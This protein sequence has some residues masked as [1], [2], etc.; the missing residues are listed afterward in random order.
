[1]KMTNKKIAIVINSLKVG[2][3]AEKTVAA[4]SNGLKK[5]GCDVTIFVFSRSEDEY[6]T[7]CQIEVLGSALPKNSLGALL[8][9][10][11]RGREIA[12]LSKKHGIE[13]VV[14]FMEEANFASLAGKIFFGNKAKVACSVRNNPEKKKLFAKLLM[15][16]L[17][18][19][20]DCLAVNSS[21]LAKLVSGLSS[22]VAVLYNPVDY[23]E[24]VRK[25]EEP[26]SAEDERLFADG[27]VF[28]NIG[29][30]HPQKGQ[31]I[32]IKSFSAIA[33]ENPAAELVIIGE[34]QSREF[35]IGLA[36]SLGV[37][38]RVHFL[39]RRNNV[40]PFLRRSKAFVLSSNWEGMPNVLLEAM[41]VGTPI[42]ATDCPTGVRE[43]VAPSS[44]S[45]D[46][47]VT[48]ERGIL[49]EVGNEKMLS[50]AMG[51]A[52][53]EDRKVFIDE[54]FLIDNVLNEWEKII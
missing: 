33:K 38:D 10:F 30:L 23:E 12:S 27:P 22:K 13:T 32:L 37:A 19:F 26:M 16:A 1:M 42:V 14:S 36:S 15:K 25:A 8:A 21:D 4:I 35:L 2:G 18:R 39:G 34:G 31:D 6:E 47:P 40:F 24:A 20:A 7:S 53:T 41:A 43:L 52:I 50:E 11:S 51:K 45:K 49:V 44:D 48:T 28:L 46:F 5:R 29:R 54:R 17:Y 9:V 3:G